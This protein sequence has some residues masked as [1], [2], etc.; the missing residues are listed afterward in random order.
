[1]GS[2]AL[3]DTVNGAL[4]T[5]TC[6]IAYDQF[7]GS[8]PPQ[9]PLGYPDARQAAGWRLVL[10]ETTHVRIDVTS[11]AFNP[12]VL[13]TD[14]TGWLVAGDH[15]IIPSMH[16]VRTLP[17]GAYNVWAASPGLTATGA[18]SLSAQTVTPCAPSDSVGAIAI[19]QTVAGALTLADCYEMPLG[20][21]AEW[22]TLAIPA[23]T[24]IRAR[25]LNATTVALV[26]LTDSLGGSS[27]VAWDGT[28]IYAVTE[29]A[30]FRIG[31]AAE[32]PGTFNLEITTCTLPC[33][34]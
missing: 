34:P 8:W 2:L 29:A 21:L 18:F 13:V 28:L 15:R 12:A 26:I 31:V 24:A 20:Y 5:T 4:E 7:W 30:Q 32:F 27:A 9:Y 17:T 14:S 1:M 6:S 3:P 23:A 11:A 10:P 19:G 22:R 33:S 25:I 16:V